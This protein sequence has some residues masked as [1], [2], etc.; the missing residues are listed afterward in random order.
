MNV[1]LL[2]QASTAISFLDPAVE[3]ARTWQP[4]WQLNVTFSL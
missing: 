4:V 1:D 2:V 3:V